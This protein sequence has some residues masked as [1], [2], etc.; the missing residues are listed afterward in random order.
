MKIPP[1]PSPQES[2]CMRGK[3]R[4][5]MMNCWLDWV[6]YWY[7]S[8]LVGASSLFANATS[9]NQVK[10]SGHVLKSS[11]TNK[12]DFSPNQKLLWNCWDWLVTI[13]QLGW[14]F[15][16]HLRNLVEILGH[17][18]VYFPA[19]TRYAKIVLAL[20]ELSFLPVKPRASAS[21]R[22]QENKNHAAVNN[23][24]TGEQ[25]LSLGNCDRNLHPSFISKFIKFP[26]I[27]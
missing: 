22:N 19:Y 8:F 4:E 3:G 13:W 21:G 9:G 5:G 2:S 11:H 24:R 20:A 15:P 7:S 18:P 1:P 27:F 12:C 25:E 6:H 17:L 14:V 23:A 16:P 26:W 10:G